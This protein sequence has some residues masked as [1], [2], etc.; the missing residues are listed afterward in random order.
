MIEDGVTDMKKKDC[1]IVDKVKR[2]CILKEIKGLCLDTA[3]KKIKFGNKT[4]ITN[5]QSFKH[6]QSR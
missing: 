3:A 1:H 2:F 4:C 5:I 6:V